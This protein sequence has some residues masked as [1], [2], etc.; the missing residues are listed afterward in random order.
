M[1]EI[2]FYLLVFVALLVWAWLAITTA[3][4]AVTKRRSPVLWIFAG[5]LSG[6]IAPFILSR[7]PQGTSLIGETSPSQFA[8]NDLELVCPQC[9]SS[10]LFSARACV[11]CG[12]S[13]LRSH[14]GPPRFDLEIM[15]SNTLEEE[16]LR[17]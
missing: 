3:V 8:E 13:V 2:L 11:S 9:G 12:N 16:D 7:L 6:P 5:M 17:Q 15:G 10:N 1:F 14:V 4:I